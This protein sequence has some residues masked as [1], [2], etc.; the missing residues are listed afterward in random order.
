[1][2]V[3]SPDGFYYIS[4]WNMRGKLIYKECMRLPET[5]DLLGQSIL[6]PFPSKIPPLTFGFCG[7]RP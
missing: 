6:I 4:S 1:M 5:N 2:S 7:T 3:S